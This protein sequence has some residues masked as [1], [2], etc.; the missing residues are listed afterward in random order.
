MV[1]V[2]T[3]FFTRRIVELMPDEDYRALQTV[4][5]ARPETGDIIRGSGGIGKMRWGV[6]GRGK[7][8]GVGVIYYWAVAPEQIL[9]LLVYAKNEAEDLTSDQLK[10]LRQVVE[11]EFS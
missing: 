9:M 5:L 10:V 8:G 2:E 4:L 6:S 11:Q 3:S 1:I 7:R